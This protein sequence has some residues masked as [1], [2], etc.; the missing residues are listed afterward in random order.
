MLI[1][2]LY[3]STTG[4]QRD[5]VTRTCNPL[6]AMIESLDAGQTLILF[7]E[8][9]RGEPEQLSEFRTGIAH[10]LA[11]RPNTPV[12]PVYMRNLG[13]TMPR[14]DLVIVP[15]FCD[16]YVGEPRVMSGNRA[17]IMA[18]LHEAFE[19]LIAEADALR[20]AHAPADDR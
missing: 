8:G 13:F 15:L 7:P 9:T 6:Q 17:A 5:K 2:R 4:Y 14:G 19:A 1:S 18:Q 20:P 16:V 11:K 12:A 10:V 3:G